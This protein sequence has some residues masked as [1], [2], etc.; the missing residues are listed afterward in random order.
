MIPID[1][2]DP[3]LL[4]QFVISYIHSANNIDE[5]ISA[6]NEALQL[7]KQLPPSSRIN[8]LIKEVENEPFAPSRPSSFTLF[9]NYFAI[10]LSREMRKA[11][12]QVI[13]LNSKKVLK[14]VYPNITPSIL[15]LGR[16]IFEKFVE[17]GWASR[18][19]THRGKYYMIK[20]DSPLFE[21]KDEPKLLAR[22]LHD[23]LVN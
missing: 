15:T 3:M 20:V 10:G 11:K 23:I 19:S 13:T 5:F 12:G 22:F 1:T 8:E 21:L 6:K 16:Y 17:L 18:Y 4:R 7:L 14:G 2:E 9:L